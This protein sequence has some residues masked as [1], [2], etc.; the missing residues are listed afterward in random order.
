MSHNKNKSQKKLKYFASFFRT[1][2]MQQCLLTH[3]EIDTFSNE[4]TF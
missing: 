2:N 3:N 4:I 1:Q